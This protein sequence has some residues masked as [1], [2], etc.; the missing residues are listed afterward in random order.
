[1]ANEVCSVLLFS[2]VSQ[3]SHKNLQENLQN[4]NNSIIYKTRTFP[5]VQQSIRAV[6]RLLSKI[7]Q[8]K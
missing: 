3:L 2:S 4:C 6:N 7:I 5:N 1:L 8:D